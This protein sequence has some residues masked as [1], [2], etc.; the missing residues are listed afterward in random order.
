MNQKLF[1]NNYN[2]IFTLQIVSKSHGTIVTKSMTS[3]EIFNCSWAIWATSLATC[4][5]VP[6]ATIVM[7]EPSLITSALDN[8][9]V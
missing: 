5:W 7:S 9:K 3:H 4:T 2:K 6:H 8:G 1:L